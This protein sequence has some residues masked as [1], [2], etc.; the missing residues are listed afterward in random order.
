[1]SRL[2]PFALLVAGA[3]AMGAGCKYLDK[4]HPEHKSNTGKTTNKPETPKAVGTLYSR[5]GGE[6]AIKKVVD[7]FVARAATDKKVN[8]ARSGHPN[9]WDPSPANIEK[10]KTH[11]V[12]FIAK[13]SGGPDNYKGRDMVTSHTGM[14]ISE[15]EFNA[16][17][18]DLALSLDAMKV[19]TREKNELLTAV[20][21]TKGQIVNK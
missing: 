20:A 3:L 16:A 6:E 1:M 19:P 21:G 9:E 5:L 12:A 11:L 8:F 14:H 13:V 4:N 15:E 10:L 7:D 18:A 2:K 17:A